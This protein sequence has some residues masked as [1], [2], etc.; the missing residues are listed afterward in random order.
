V[1]N[2]LAGT[3]SRLPESTTDAF[4]I[5]AFMSFENIIPMTD[6]NARE[7]LYQEAGADYSHYDRFGV[8]MALPPGF[9][10]EPR[11]TTM[12]AKPRWI[13]LERY[14]WPILSRAF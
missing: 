9:A 3:I 2:F 10:L 8:T 14:G 5:F 4:R 7:N 12:G 6:A 1:A 13:F 11:P